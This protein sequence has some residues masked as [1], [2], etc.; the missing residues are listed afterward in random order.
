MN[1]LKKELKHII[2]TYKNA[3]NKEQAFKMSAYMRHQFPFL[4]IQAPQR[5]DLNKQLAE[6]IKAFKIEHLEWL[7]MQLWSEKEREFQ[8]L[9]L[10][11]IN[12]NK[13]HLLPSHI[14]FLIEIITEKSWWDTV[15]VIAPNFIGYL[16]KNY[17]ELKEEYL[18]QWVD[19]PSI[20]LNRTALIFQLRYKENTDFELLKQLIE[21]LK[22]KKDFFIRKAIGWA[23]RNYSKCEPQL[24]EEYIKTASLS[25]LS[26]KEGLKYIRNHSI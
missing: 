14:D 10:Y 2:Q 7:I 17:P 5:A 23:L 25:P 15:D 13:R 8:Y 6:Q 12:Q 18:P 1:L 11:I 4:G 20:W 3:A 24:V 9:A 26:E 21:A 16:F 19:S 22:H